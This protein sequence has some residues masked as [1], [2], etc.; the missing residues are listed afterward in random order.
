VKHKRGIVRGRAHPDNGRVHIVGVQDRE[1]LLHSFLLRCRAET[2]PDR[3]VA[4]PAAEPAKLTRT[5]RCIW[6]LDLSEFMIASSLW[7]PSKSVIGGMATL[8]RRMTEPRPV[9]RGDAD[10]PYSGLESKLLATES[11]TLKRYVSYRSNRATDGHRLRKAGHGTK[12]RFLW[13][14]GWS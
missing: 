8:A 9:P 5:L 2:A 10:H 13:P 6:V 3:I 7:L 1:G 12:V 14:K 11:S 4:P